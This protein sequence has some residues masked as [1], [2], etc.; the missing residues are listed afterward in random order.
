MFR[1]SRDLMEHHMAI[2]ST[3]EATM[4]FTKKAFR[5][6][7][8][9]NN[10]TMVWYLSAVK[11]GRTPSRDEVYD[12]I[13][14]VADTQRDNRKAFSMA[15]DSQRKQRFQTA[16]TMAWYNRGAYRQYGQSH[17]RTVALQM[18][19]RLV[20]EPVTSYTKVPMLG[21]THLYFCSPVYGHSDYNKVRTCLLNGPLANDL[22]G[23][24]Y[25]PQ[26]AWCTRVVELGE[27]LYA[28]KC[29]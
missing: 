27:R 23:N 10:Q 22:H 12:L 8:K 20:T 6:A 28:K 2:N 16:E 13:K 17:Y 29:G 11:L 1:C 26:A 3:Q 19:R 4:K 21:R 14:A 24:R 5:V 7:L 15:Y 25:D 9:A 18:L